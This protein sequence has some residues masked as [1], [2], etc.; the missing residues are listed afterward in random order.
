MSQA[1]AFRGPKDHSW[2]M[3]TGRTIV[4]PTTA[5]DDEIKR[6][7][8]DVCSYSGSHISN[9]SIRRVRSR[10]RIIELKE[11]RFDEELRHPASQSA[12]AAA[13]ANCGSINAAQRGVILGMNPTRVVGPTDDILTDAFS[14]G[15]LDT[16]LVSPEPIDRLNLAENPPELTVTTV[17]G[18]SMIPGET[19]AP[20]IRS[21]NSKDE[22]AVERVYSVPS[23]RIRS[24]A[25]AIRNTI[26]K[27][28]HFRGVPKGEIQGKGVSNVIGNG[29]LWTNCVLVQRLG[30]IGQP[31]S[32]MTFLDWM[33][34]GPLG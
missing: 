9:K 4:V 15:G 10:H 18:S 14:D 21:L 29:V 5:T 26:F 30:G 24:Q 3:S 16:A 34:L 28:P 13:H 33:L 1:A 7:T 2:I 22:V 20:K 31:Y 17:T 32:L 23:L 25:D 11:K 19:V 12:E 27:R 8:L 6:A